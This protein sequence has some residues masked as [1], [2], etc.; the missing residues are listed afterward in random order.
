[1]ISFLKNMKNLVVDLKAVQTDSYKAELGASSGAETFFKAGAG[2]GAESNSFGSTTLHLEAP[3]NYEDKLEKT[4]T[5]G[6]G[7]DQHSLEARQYG[8]ARLLK[9]KSFS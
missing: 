9:L 5:V 2:A 4:G 6:I 8:V 7:H 3:C 1:V